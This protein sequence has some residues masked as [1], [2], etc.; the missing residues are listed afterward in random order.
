[1]SR[2]VW[3]VAL[4]SGLVL[5]QGTPGIT[6]G[7]ALKKRAYQTYA[8]A[9]YYLD[10]TG[11]DSNPCV[12]T[13][14]AA[15]LTLNAVY[16]KIP[17]IVRHDITINVAAGSY[18]FDS[19][20]DGV[21]FGTVNTSGITGPTVS[22]DGPALTAFTPAT[23]T[24]SGTLTVAATGSNPLPIFTDGAQ[25]WTVNDLRGQFLT[26]TSGVYSGRSMPIVANTATTITTQAWSTTNP[27]A[28]DTYAIQTPAATITGTHS[29]T[30]IVGNAGTISFRRLTL[31]SGASTT[32]P[33]MYAAYNTQNIILYLQNI[34]VLNPAGV[35]GA[36]ASY[37]STAWSG[38]PS[39]GAFYAN[40]TAGVAVY[41]V[42]TAPVLGAAGYFVAYSG[43]TYAYYSHQRS[44]VMS[45]A[46]IVAETAGAAAIAMVASGH[47]G[48]PNGVTFGSIH[49]RCP[50]GSTG[51]GLRQQGGGIWQAN[52]EAVNC[53]T[54]LIVGQTRTIFAASPPQTT[55]IDGALTCTNTTTCV[56]ILN[57]GRLNLVPVP[58]LTGVTNDYTIDGTT[59]TEAFFGALPS[60]PRIQSAAGSFLERN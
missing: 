43:T 45:Q 15:C 40:A 2:W 25:T 59:Y 8:A 37:R 18:T 35:L 5:A 31:T 44:Q 41:A 32:A 13:G 60:P 33:T 42:E 7:G 10:P 26:M 4:L 47:Q 46:S 3:T 24:A 52:F 29:I 56:Q 11:S 20:W 38:H 9:T 14:T 1:M 30:G 27:L 39:S 50:A 22:I 6:R 57:G 28:G 12:G 16:A 19:R 49:V 53:G 51:V 54:G 58:T 23:G 21:Q 55:I 34:Q 36:A 17:R 48:D